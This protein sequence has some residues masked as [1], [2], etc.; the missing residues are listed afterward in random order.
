V[1]HL[2]MPLAAVL[3]VVILI[4]LL[5][6]HIGQVDKWIVPNIMNVSSHNATSSY[7]ARDG[8][9]YAHVGGV[10]GVFGIAEAREAVD[11][12]IHPQRSIRRHQHIDAQIKLLPSHQHGILDVARYHVST[13]STRQFVRMCMFSEYNISR[14]CSLHLRFL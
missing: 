12:L 9:M 11:V 8:S 1:T 14:A 3:R 4:V 6:G 7:S 5:D 2:H 10:V 13:R